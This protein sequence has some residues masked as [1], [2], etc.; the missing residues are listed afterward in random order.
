MAQGV[1]NFVAPLFGGIPATGTIARTVTNVRAGAHTPV[2]GIVHALTLLVIVLRRPRRSPPT[3]RSRRW[4]ASCS[5]SPGTWA[6]GAS[7]R[8]CG[9]SALPYRA[10]LL[11]TFVLTVVFDLTVAVQVGLVLACVFFIYR[12]STLF[13]VEPARRCRR[14]RA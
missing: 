6:S 9:S 2:A 7:S 13:R 5:S 12:M 1:A 10:I 8:G 4:P 3:C 14:R 11:G